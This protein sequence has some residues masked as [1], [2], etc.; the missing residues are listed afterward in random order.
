VECWDDGELEAL[1]PLQERVDAM[2]QPK[3]YTLFDLLL[4][5]LAL[6]VILPALWMAV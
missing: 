6:A 3:T 2:R 4:P 1:A 5:L